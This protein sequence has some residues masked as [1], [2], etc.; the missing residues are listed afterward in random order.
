MNGAPAAAAAPATTAS[1]SAKKPL[2]LP[3]FC[4]TCAEDV[5]ATGWVAHASSIAHQMGMAPAATA[6][7]VWLPPANPGYRMLEAM[8]WSEASGR[9]LGAHEQG[10]LQ[11]VPTVL[12]EDRRGVGAAPAKRRR[13]HVEGADGGRG[14][15]LGG[16]GAAAG[17]ASA[18]SDAARRPAPGDSTARV[19]HFPPHSDY[20]A[21]SSADAVS[22]AEREQDARPGGKAGRAGA[23][24]ATARSRGVPVAAAAA[25]GA[26]ARTAGSAAARQREQ[27]EKAA[28]RRHARLRAEVLMDVPSGFE[29]LF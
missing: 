29:A 5:P 9:G 16:G 21:A 24:R 19:T 10:R 23:G 2:T 1:S 28:A 13:L 3:R 20:E 7:T 11:P 26:G 6:R 17:R 8:G 22:R 15:A 18:R 12:K 25:A 27:A 4:P 14:A